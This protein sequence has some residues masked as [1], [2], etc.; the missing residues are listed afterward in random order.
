MKHDIEIRD[1][2]LLISAMAGWLVFVNLCLW[3][4]E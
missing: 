1:W 3:F 2:I 4:L